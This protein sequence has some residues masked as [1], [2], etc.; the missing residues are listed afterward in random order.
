MS[1]MC[2]N[3]WITV[4]RLMVS[5]TEI[6]YIN[7][8]EFRMAGDDSVMVESDKSS[9]RGEVRCSVSLKTDLQFQNGMAKTR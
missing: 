3:P 2:I 6:T 9:Q 4:D 7:N 1:L 5:T 8:D